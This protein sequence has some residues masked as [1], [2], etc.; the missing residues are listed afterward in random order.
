ML[1]Q[2]FLFFFAMLGAFNGIGVVP[3][4]A[5]QGQTRGVGWP[6]WC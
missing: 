5:G 2:H 4:V 3:V 1:S 6:S